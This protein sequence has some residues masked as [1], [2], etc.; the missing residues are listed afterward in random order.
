MLSDALLAVNR[1]AFPLPMAQLLVLSTYYT[2]QILITRHALGGQSDRHAEPGTA[3][4][5]LGASHS[6]DAGHAGHAPASA[7]AERV[8]PTR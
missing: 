2:A 3:A 8:S 4:S 1:F 7:R 6:G 5:A